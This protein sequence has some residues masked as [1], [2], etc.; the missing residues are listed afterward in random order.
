[1]ARSRSRK[2]ST[3]RVARALP[4]GPLKMS[5]AG[6]GFVQTAEG[7]FYIAPGKTGDAFDGDVVEVARVHAHGRDRDDSQNHGERLEGRVASVLQRAHETVVGRYEIAEPFG[8]VV[9]ED[10]RIAHDIFTLRRDAPHVQDGDIVRVRMTA[11]P[12]RR[13]PAQG[14]VVEVLGHAGDPA[15]DV[16]LIV[17]RHKLRSAFPDEVLAE[18]RQI[19]FDADELPNVTDVADLTGMLCFTIDPDDAKDYDDAVSVQRVAYEGLPLVANARPLE[20]GAPAGDKPY[21]LLTVHIADV[22]HYVQWGS[23]IDLEARARSTSVYLVDRVLPM[24]P[25]RLSND[26]C[27]LKP[28]VYRRAFSVKMLIDA[29]GELRDAAFTPSV[30]RSAARLTYSQALACLDA[31]NRGDEATAADAVRLGARAAAPQVASSIGL[32]REVTRAL[33]A[34]RTARGCLDFAS[35]EA[36]VELDGSGRP[37]RV[38]VRRKNPATM[39]IEE[40]ML[41]ANEAV[42]GYLQRVGARSIYRVHEAPAS[43]DLRELA[44]LLLEFGYGKHASLSRLAAGDPFAM[45]AV[46]AAA[47]GRSEEYLISALAV[48]AQRRACYKDACEAHYGLASDAYTHFTSPIRRYPDLMVH[49]M[50]KAQLLGRDGFTSA[51]EAALPSI[52][53]HAS[54]AERTAEDASRESNELKLYEL[55]A[56]RVGQV[57]DGVISGVASQGFFVRLE[58]TAEG[59]VSLREAGEYF[60]FDAARRSL[61]GSDTGEFY[62][63]GA[64]V[65][66]RIVS[67]NPYARR[68]DFALVRRVGPRL[69]PKRS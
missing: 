60:I 69:L 65:R 46:L 8:V 55:L 61:T 30:I 33:H 53:E 66:V 57:A 47:K 64:K 23:A 31:L 11:Y 21:Y 9:P 29:K 12:S 62:R 50:L 38:N 7:E 45:Q 16:D 28:G 24:L 3:R 17:A 22:S 35:E 26:I 20:P 39:L 44:D 67:V 59:F 49:R 27:S 15:S 2:S 36:R 42:A 1:M 32:L 14:E 19:A 25:E 4:S 37:L 68:A 13:E 58:D 51:M 34:K 56:G 52:A 63:M 10:P 43:S 41:A 48:R 54:A 5:A 40:A 6:Y 18:A